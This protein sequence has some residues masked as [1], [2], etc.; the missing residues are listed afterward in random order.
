MAGKILS[1]T[2]AHIVYAQ[3]GNLFRIALDELGDALQWTRIAA[4]NGLLDPFLPAETPL[5]LIIPPARLAAASSGI[6]GG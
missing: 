4:A 6:I 5:A 2:A 1:A 3:G